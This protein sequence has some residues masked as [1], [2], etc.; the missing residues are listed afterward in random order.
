MTDEDQK[1]GSFPHGKGG[2]GG[3]TLSMGVEQKKK[4]LEV[5]SSVWSLST[6]LFKSVPHS[7]ATVRRQETAFRLV[8]RDVNPEPGGRPPC[9]TLAPRALLR[10]PCRCWPCHPSGPPTYRPTGSTAN[11]V[12]SGCLS[13]WRDAGSVAKGRDH[14]GR[15]AGASVSKPPQVCTGAPYTTPDLVPPAQTLAAHPPWTGPPPG[16]WMGVVGKASAV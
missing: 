2:G 7:L 14:P 16:G 15:L 5:V 12:G 13:L 8:G 6:R 10:S 4:I 1:P 11:G 3:Y 9:C